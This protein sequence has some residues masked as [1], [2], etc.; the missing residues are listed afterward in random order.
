MPSRPNR[1]P[2]A[3]FT[4]LF[5]AVRLGA[6][7]PGVD[8]RA[9][10]AR[11]DLHYPGAVE[12]SED[13]MPIGNGRM[14]SLVWT[15]PTAL[16]FQVNRNDVQPISCETSSFFERN[17][18]YMGGCGFVD[19][20]LGMAGVDVF[21]AQ[22]SPQHLSIADG[23]LTIAG[24]GVTARIVAWPHRDVFA[25][26]L[27]D[28]RAIPQP[29]AVSLRMLRYAGQYHA[30]LETQNRNHIVTIRTRQHTATSQ[31]HIRGDRIIL[32]Q[33]FREGAHVAKSAVAIAVV[34]R[35]AKATFVHDA[36]VRLAAP[37]GA[38]RVSILV[39]SAA[40][41]NA[42]DD[43]IAA[44]LAGIDATGGR[45]FDQLA[46]ETAGWW[47]A[48]WARGW[49]EL[50]SR[51]GVADYV[52]ENYHY[53]L[54][55]MGATSRGRF[56]TKFNGMLWNTAGDLRTWGA[57]HWFAN[58]SCLYEALFASNRLELLD[59]MFDMYSGMFDAAAVAARQQWGSEGIYIPE[60]VWFDGLA[61]LP[62]DVAAE[63]RELYL[64]R[65]PWP[66][67]SDR[68]MAYARTRLPHSSRW[69][70]WGG[71]SWVEG[72][73][74]PTERGFG[75]YGPV[76]HILGTTAKVAYLFWRRYEYTLDREW[77]KTRAYPMIKGAA[78]FYR[79]FPNVRRGEDGR[80]HIH[81]VNSNESVVGAR[82]TDEDLSA[83]RAIFAVAGRAAEILDVDPELRGQWTEFLGRL[84]PLPTSSDSDAIKP[85]DYTGPRVFV[86][87][88]TPVVNGR[89][90]TPDGNSLPMWFFDLCN[91]DSR[92]A[93][94]T[95]LA[96]ATFDRALRGGPPSADTPVGVLSKIAIAGAALGRVDA[97]RH[98]I[99]N[100]MRSLTAEREGAYRGG[101]PLLNRL[102]LRE[103][104]QAFDA[105][106]LGR[107]AEALQLALLNS[108]PPGPAQ[109]PAIRLFAAWPAEWDATFML[110]ARGGFVITAAHKDGRI[111]S[112]EIHSEAGAACRLHNPWPG[113][114]VT[115]TRDGTTTGRIRGALLVFPTRIGERVRLERAN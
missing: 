114:E 17:S 110:R 5:G 74:A 96:N 85:A 37:A 64:L 108:S 29:L 43:V 90:F 71:G 83:M 73:W 34:G 41:L 2:L 84:A 75:P 111:G 28:R 76:T 57:Q 6:A 80:M 3:C 53:Y 52:A 56:P 45:S 59:P 78:E 8:V 103:G 97:T 25:I 67:R 23:L 55:L 102:S 66:Q 19:V 16:H 62:D 51:D 30:A 13:G 68:F 63:M 27:D 31:L 32:T 69:N 60:T 33:E 38:G 89:G 21:T 20:D 98:L 36:E 48:F 101:R 86:R 91:L 47:R 113:K 18:D 88:R 4:L 1:F 42:G 14:G 82:D 104:H 92:D 61:R 72:N 26:E 70:W 81:H 94:M 35:M 46:S 65:K 49:I 15:T 50:H 7:E 100:Q 39:A 107:A 77:L 44:A 93:D 22:N 58:L 106:R 95:A 24:R 109:E 87:G 11:S 40:T 79:H 10:V 12:R 115:L 112:A 54:Y 105:Q 9:L 99:P